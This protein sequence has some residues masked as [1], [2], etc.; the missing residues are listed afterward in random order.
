[1]ERNELNQKRDLLKWTR[2]TLSTK[3]HF[4]NRVGMLNDLEGK[5]F[6]GQPKPIYTLTDKIYSFLFCNNLT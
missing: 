3:T 4:C 6:S 5:A 2:S 1:M